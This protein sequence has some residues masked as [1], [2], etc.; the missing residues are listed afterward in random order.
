MINDDDD[1]LEWDKGGAAKHVKKPQ[2]KEQ[3]QRVGGGGRGG[4][5]GEGARARL[6]AA[7]GTPEAV[8]KVI[9]YAQDRKAVRQMVDYISRKGDLEVE[10]KDGSL[11]HGRDGEGGTMELV[12]GWSAHFRERVNAR[13]AMHL[14]VSA[15][16]GTDRAAFR[17]AARA[18]AGRAFGAGYDYA[19]TS[20][21]DESHP[22]VHILVVRDGTKNVYLGNSKSDLQRYREIMAEAA[23][24][25]GIAMNAT[26]RAMRA[27]AEKGEKMAVR[28][29]RERAGTSQVDEKAAAEVLAEMAGG[30][31]PDRPWI[32]AM[33]RR[34]AAER[35]AYEDL[36]QSFDAIGTRMGEDDTGMMRSAGRLVRRQG[37]ALRQIATRR[38]H[39]R[40]IAERD[41]LDRRRDGRQAA[42]TLAKAYREDQARMKKREK[43]IPPAS[44]VAMQKKLSSFDREF[45]M[46]IE[47]LIQKGDPD[48]RRLRESLDVA[49]DRGRDRERD[50]DFEK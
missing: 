47:Q 13:N 40:R 39:M 32:L 37:M 33:A 41:R 27:V 25:H 35:E 49:Q 14:Q 15:P 28:K 1:F 18:F 11:V 6:R 46:R 16:P 17:N 9:S 38:D 45:G 7:S 2:R 23:G 19:L 3:P 26:P 30:P 20:H 12:E 48:A 10:T 44:E 4:R 29:A 43:Q 24:D 34:A 22:H 8:V 50:R 42:R 21:E 36:A 31:V 5:G